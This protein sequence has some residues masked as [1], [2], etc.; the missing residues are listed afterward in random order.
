M[1]KLSERYLDGLWS[2]AIR[3]KAHGRCQLCGAPAEQAHHVVPRRKKV[4]RHDIENGVALCFRCHAYAHTARGNRDV[5]AL[6]DMEY[7]MELESV[8]LK[9]YLESR[10]ITRAEFSHLIA[11]RL[12]PYI[13]G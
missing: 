11:D 13:E 9:D 10:E 3:A 7:L 2:R 5:E 8:L 1:K 6:V 4:L 12:K